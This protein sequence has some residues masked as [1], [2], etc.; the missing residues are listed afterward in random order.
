MRELFKRDVAAPV[1]SLIFFQ[2]LTIMAMNAFANAPDKVSSG[3]GIPESF[4]GIFT[5]ICYLSALTFGLFTSAPLDRFGA[6]RCC[7]VTLLVGALGMTIFTLATPWSFVLSAVMVGFAHG[8]MNPAGS[9]VIMRHITSKWRPLLFSLKQTSIPI[10]GTLAGFL[11]PTLLIFTEWQATMLIIAVTMTIAAIIAQPFR[12]QTAPRH[13]KNRPRQKENIWEPIQL[14]F[15]KGP[16]RALSLAAFILIGCQAC[17]VSF[18]V[19]YL[20]KEIKLELQWAGFIFGLAH[21]TSIIARIYLG[22]LADRVVKTKTILGSCGVITGI[23]FFLLAAFPAGGS[24]WLLCFLGIILG[25][26]N[27]GWVGLYFG[28]ISKLAP[29]GKAAQVTAGSQIYA[30]GSFVL[31]PPIFTIFIEYMNNYAMGFFIV[32]IA[33][34]AAGVRFLT[35]KY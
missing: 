31:I 5:A 11:V 23:C 1:L 30:F 33:G 24:F 17:V 10:G 8:P 9:F 18:L 25:N 34:L 26:A 15:Q 14:V 3:Y 13:K 4:T 29:N 32:G 16:I 20:V 21:G 2:S 6:V 22:I 19:L 28:E 35:I 12:D 27:L 7:Q